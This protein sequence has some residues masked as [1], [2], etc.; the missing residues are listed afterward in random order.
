MPTGAIRMQ[1]YI[2]RAIGNKCLNRV[3]SGCKVFRIR[4]TPTATTKQLKALTM[5]DKEI[6]A[7]LIYAFKIDGLYDGYGVTMAWLSIVES[8][9]Q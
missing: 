6:T 5:N 9:L 1:P 2:Y 4:S 8:C 3:D 7:A